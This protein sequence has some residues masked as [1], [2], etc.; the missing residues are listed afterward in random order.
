MRIAESQMSCLSYICGSK[1]FFSYGQLVIF[2][3]CIDNELVQMFRT[4]FIC[5]NYATNPGTIVIKK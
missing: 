1:S 5:V 4:F 3:I 2:L